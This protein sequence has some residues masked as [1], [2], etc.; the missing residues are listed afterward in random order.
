MKLRMYFGIVKTVIIAV[1]ILFA[2]ALA[3]VDIAMLAGAKGIETSMPAIAGVSLGASVLIAVAGALL[4]LNSFYKFDKDKLV[5]MLGVF[6][7]VVPYESVT[8]VRQNGETSE[9]YLFAK[10]KKIQDGETVIRF[11]VDKGKIDDLLEAIR[12]AMP[13]LIIEVFTPENSEPKH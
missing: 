4:L 10:G 9:V 11:N 12:Q 7:D 5:V 2:L 13:D 1:V 3:G 8:A 6:K